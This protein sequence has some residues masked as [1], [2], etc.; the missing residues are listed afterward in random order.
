MH[1]VHGFS[2]ARCAHQ[3]QRRASVCV[4]CGLSKLNKAAQQTLEN[5]C[6]RHHQAKIICPPK[7]HNFKHTYSFMRVFNGIFQGANSK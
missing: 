6:C 7:R 1:S 3:F 4:Y 2:L 5:R